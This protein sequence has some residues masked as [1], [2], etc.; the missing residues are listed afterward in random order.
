MLSLKKSRFRILCTK[1]E[2][3]EILQNC[4]LSYKKIERW[5]SES[6]FTINLW[7]FVMK[8]KRLA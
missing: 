5:C 3:L 6:D 4:K 1:V 2:N 7:N 8:R